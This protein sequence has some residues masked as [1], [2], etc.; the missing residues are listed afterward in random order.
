MGTPPLSDELA[1]ETY[2]AFVEHGSNKAAAARALNISRTTFNSRFETAVERGIAK[3]KPV[4]PPPLQMPDFPDGD[5]PTEKIIDHLEERY[6]ARR[7]SFDA[8]TWFEVKVR[9]KKPIGV[10]WFG[11]PHMDDNGCNWPL[12]RSHAQ[13][14]ADTDG[15]YGVNIGDSLNNWIGRLTHLYAKQD[16]SYATGLKLV[17]WFMLDSG[18]TWLCWLLGNHDAWGELSKILAQMGKKYRTQQIVCHDWEARFC[19]AF[20]GGW[21]PRIYVSHDF[22]GHSQWNPL[23]GPMKEGQM[24]EDA[25]IY[26]AGHKHNYARFVWENAKRGNRQQEFVRVRGYKEMDDYARRGGFPEQRSGAAVLTVFDPRDESI[27]SFENI[28]KGVAFLRMLRGE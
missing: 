5:I 7:A 6:T 20:P 17:Q 8:H 1:M 18:V 12:L 16:A 4:E 3:R 28:E 2:E 26:V 10:L 27:V 22:K 9:D 23:H 21:K 15:L 19:L 11:D 13:M 24:G 25:D 14:C